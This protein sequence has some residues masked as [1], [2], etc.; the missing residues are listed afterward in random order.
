MFKESTVLGKLHRMNTNGYSSHSGR[1]LPFWLNEWMI[2]CLFIISLDAL[3][4]C[5]W[6]CLER[7]IPFT[8][9]TWEMQSIWQESNNCHNPIR[10]L[11]FLLYIAT[12]SHVHFIVMWKLCHKLYVYVH[13][14]HFY[15][16]MKYAL[17]PTQYLERLMHYCSLLVTPL[18]V[19][20]YKTDSLNR[21]S[22]K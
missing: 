8:L 1:D 2:V 20:F 4:C 3:L 21:F 22:T 9:F 18:L 12:F 11:M 19:A 15:M 17:S 7:Q 16:K 13:I 14:Y 6:N 10:V 5:Y